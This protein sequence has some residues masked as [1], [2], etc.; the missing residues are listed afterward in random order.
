MTFNPANYRALV[1]VQDDYD[2]KTCVAEFR[3][4]LQGGDW[5]E[6]TERIELPAPKGPIPSGTTLAVRTALRQ[7]FL[8]AGV[9]YAKA[10]GVTQIQAPGHASVAIAVADDAGPRIADPGGITAAELA[11]MQ[12]VYRDGM[13]EFAF[14]NDLADVLQTEVVVPRIVD[15]GELPLHNDPARPLVA[16]GGGKDSIVSL[17]ALRR[18]GMTPVSFVVN[19]NEITTSVVERS[20]TELLPVRRTLDP[21]LFELNA[22][23][24]LN[25]HIPVTAINSLLGV[26]VSILHGLGP[27]V[28]SNESS[29]SAPNVEWHG[30]PINHQWSKGIEAE[31][32]IRAAL[33]SRFG[34]DVTLYFSLL[35]HLNELSIAER[36]SRVTSYDDMVTSCN[37]AFTITKQS[38]KRW[39]RDCPKCR[40]VFLALACFMPAARVTGMFG[41]DMLREESQLAGYRELLGLIAFKPFECVGELD[42]SVAAAAYLAQKP[43]WKDASVIVALNEELAA[44]GRSVPSL[45]SVLAERGPSRAPADYRVALDAL[46]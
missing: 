8:V 25:G 43:E 9:S 37:R 44:S 38:G 41:G 42:E 30:H 28:M 19:P 2:P 29:A 45:E 31:R 14:T 16:C 7:A 32:L 5:V 12:G 3:Y 40:F 23:G 35:R 26:A 18:A 22:D 24:A 34:E 33:A 39:C 1:L 21:K 6:F 11:L 27:L 15:P 17:E 4:A 20:E 46:P 13:G 36:F 10:A